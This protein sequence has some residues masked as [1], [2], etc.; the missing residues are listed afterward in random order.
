MTAG[1]RR[2][3]AL[4]GAVLLLGGCLGTTPSGFTGADSE[5]VCAA[6][7]QLRDADRRVADTEF[8]SAAMQRVYPAWVAAFAAAAEVAPEEIE[9]RLSRVA[10]SYEQYWAGLQ[11]IRFDPERVP[12]VTGKGPATEQDSILV[13]NYFSEVCRLELDV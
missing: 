13:Q 7:K 5:A 8:G 12:E 11:R 4:A 2:P 1:A 10:R 6:G 9:P 3:L